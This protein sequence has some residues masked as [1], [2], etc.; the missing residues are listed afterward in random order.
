MSFMRN[1]DLG[2]DKENILLIPIDRDIRNQ[3]EAVK[4]NLLQNSSIL[5][6]TASK[7]APSGFLNDAPGFE[8]ELNGEVRNRPFNMPHNRVW[9]DFFKTY[10]MEIIAGRDLSID[11]PTDDS[12]A[13]ILNETACSRLG[14]DNPNDVLGVRFKAA[15]YVEGKVIGVVKDFNYETLRNDI[16]PVVTFIG[17][18]VNTMAIRIA[19]GNYQKS[20]EHIKNVFSKYNPGI[21]LEYSF[22]DDRLDA[23]Y[24]NE[25]NMMEMFGYFS[26]FAL[27]IGC[28]GLFGLAAFTAEQKTK[29][30]GIRKTLG[31]SVGNITFLLSY[32][33]AAWVLIA[34]AIAL[35]IIYIYMNDWL[36]N[37]A[38][39]TNIEISMFL[40][41]ITISLVIAI[42]TVGSQT[43]K[44]AIQNPVKA[45]RTE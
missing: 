33:F 16:V 25:A 37:F 44:V 5:S 45:L 2:F 18:Y 34:N 23:L 19:P 20:I 24:K 22:L 41:S 17:G 35:P 31:A 15:G 32:Q 27:I 8:I 11:Y 4:K 9:H 12:L 14:I 36:N 40:I 7:R 38:F 43:I 10:K 39:R 42:V 6:V 3:Y 30:I 1:A 13:Y 28:L 26:V 21:T 29:E